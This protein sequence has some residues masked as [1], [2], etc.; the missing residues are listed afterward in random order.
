MD[1]TRFEAV[2]FD[3][4]GTLVDWETGILGA[5]TPVLAAHDVTME[6]DDLI[7]LY[8]RVEAEIESGDYQ[9]YRRVLKGTARRV[10]EACGF[11]PDL[12]EEECLVDSF[13]HWKPF[14]DTCKALQRL[15]RHYKLGIISN[16]DDDLFAITAQMLGEPFDEIVTAQQMHSYKPAHRNFETAIERL[17]VRKEHLLHVAQ[18]VYHDIVPARELGIST[19]WVTR[20]ESAGGFGASVPCEGHPNLTVPDLKTLA[21]LVEEAFSARRS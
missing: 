17:G 20:H 3:C 13:S 14:P 8:G 1:L 16:V 12:T 2:T 6:P 4:Y 10:C 21:D 19:V 9:P 15:H 11:L 7:A 18:S 5:F